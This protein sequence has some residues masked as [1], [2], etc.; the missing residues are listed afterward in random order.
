MA[1]DILKLPKER[2]LQEM[3][4]RFPDTSPT[5]HQTLLAFLRVS[6]DVLN[7]IERYFEKHGLSVGRFQILLLLLRERE[8]GINPSEL[9]EQ[10][11]VTRATITGLLDGLDRAGLVWR[12]K[13]S[14]DR[15]GITIRI[16]SSG[17]DLMEKILPGHYRRI[18]ILMEKMNSTDCEG[19][20][21]FLQ[22]IREG[23]D[24]LE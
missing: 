4:A 19:M 7:S 6:S 22:K 2:F 21:L 15:R 18:S 12:E 1:F 10:A 13:D 14:E 16:T 5:V 3:A 20:N 8:R 9:A 17:I 23:L 11:G 24:D